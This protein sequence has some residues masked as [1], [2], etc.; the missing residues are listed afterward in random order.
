MKKLIFD[1]KTLILGNWKTI[2]V[3]ALVVYFVCYYSD[4]KQGINDGWLNK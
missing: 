4:I 2:L 3:L 1:L